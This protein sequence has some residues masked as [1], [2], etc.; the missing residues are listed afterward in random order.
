V[1]WFSTFLVGLMLNRT[2]DSF[3]QAGAC[4]CN[5]ID[6]DKS[7]MSLPG[8]DVLLSVQSVWAAGAVSYIFLTLLPVWQNKAWW[9]RIWEFPRVQAGYLGVAILASG[10]WIKPEWPS[11]LLLSACLLYTSPS[12]RDRTRY[13]M[14]SSA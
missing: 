1:L 14:P 5:P 7:F 6:R 4:Y 10:F 2:R 11:L 3:N 12:P 13:R 8:L 9:V